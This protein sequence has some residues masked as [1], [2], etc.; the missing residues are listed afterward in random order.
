MSCVLEAVDLYR[1]YHAGDDETLALR[2]VSLSVEA[3]EI[4]AIAGVSGSGKSTLLACLA[5]LDE[6]DGGTVHV[7][8]D[9]LTRQ[10]EARR[11]VIRSRSIGML[12]QSANLLC[13]LD[14]RA[15]VLLAQ[16]LGGL[17]D[18]R[19]VDELLEHVGLSRR[20]HARLIELSG[21]ELARA[22]LAVALAND[23]PLLL[24]DE[25][26]GELDTGTAREIVA[27]LRARAEAGIAVVAVTHNAVLADAADRVLELESGRLAA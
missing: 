1:F 6:P 23:P 8:G 10:S 27:L 11:A 9:R 12:F 7:L 3:G 20:S 19:R 24:A 4:V 25:P 14:V 26:T 21:G 2:G 22:G 18:A 5:G 13:H 16:R 15:N 17:P